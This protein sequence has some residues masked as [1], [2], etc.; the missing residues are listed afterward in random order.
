[1]AG[2]DNC[3][4]C[5]GRK[6]IAESAVRGL[7]LLCDLSAGP[8]CPQPEW[9]IEIIC[10]ANGQTLYAVLLFCEGAPKAGM[11]PS[12]FDLSG[13]A[14]TP[15]LPLRSCAAQ[16]DWEQ[17]VLCDRGNSNHQFFSRLGLMTDGNLNPDLTG[18]FEL[19]GVTAYTPVGP[20][21][22]C[23]AGD[24]EQNVFCD[25]SVSPPK[26]FISR[27]RFDENGD[28]A[29]DDT[30][31]FELD[32][33][34]VY[35]P[36]G[37][38]ALCDPKAPNTLL[39]CDTYVAL[40]ALTSHKFLRHYCVDCTSGT[41]R[42]T[43]LDG[44]TAY[45][46]LGTVGLCCQQMPVG[47][48]CYTV[49]AINANWA[50]S[51]LAGNTL[52]R[53]D[54]AK[55]TKSPQVPNLTGNN[56]QLIAGVGN[57]PQ[58]FVLDLGQELYNVVLNFTLF[59]T[60]Q[61]ETLTG[62]SPAFT[63]ATGDVTA[64]ASNTALTPTLADGN[65][66]VTFAGPVQKITFVWESTGN[67]FS[68][69]ATVAGD[70]LR[71][72]TVLRDC[73][74][75][76][77]YLDKETGAVAASPAFHDCV[78]LKLSGNT[79]I[80]AC[81]TVTI[82]GAAAPG[83]CGVNQQVIDA[84]DIQDSEEK[85]PTTGGSAVNVNDNDLEMAGQAEPGETDHKIGV[86]FTANI[87]QGATICSAYVQF[88]AEG[89]TSVDPF[90][91]RVEGEN[92]DNSAAF[93]TT[94]GMITART[95]TTANVNWTPAAW[96]NNAAGAAQRTPELKTIVQEIVNRAG[97]VAGNALAIYVTPTTNTGYRRAS[98]ILDGNEAPKLHVEYVLNGVAA[99]TTTCVHFFKEVDLST[100]EATG[101][102]Y[103]INTTTGV[104]EAYTPVGVVNEGAC[105]CPGFSGDEG[106]N[107]QVLCMEDSTG[108]Q[109]A[110]VVA[111]DGNSGAYKVVGNYDLAFAGNYTP[112]GLSA[113]CAGTPDPVDV[114]P[115]RLCDNN[116]SFIR[117][118]IYGETG[119]VTGT[120]DTALDNVTAYTPVGVVHDC[121]A[122]A[123]TQATI[124]ED[125]A[126]VGRAVVSYGPNLLS[127]GDLESS[128]GLGAT[129]APAVG[130]TT[131][132][133]PSGNIFAAG[134]QT[135]GFFATN[136]GQVTGNN[137]AAT[138]IPALG[139][140]SMA[141][142][143]G[144]NLALAILQWTNIY[145]ENGASYNLEADAAII[146]GPFGVGIRVD[147]VQIVAM[148]APAANGVWQKTSSVFT[149]T[150]ATGYHTVGI[151]SNSGVAAGNDHCFDNFSLRRAY[152]ATA[153]NRTNAPY[154][155]TVRAI[156]DQVVETANC[157][158][159][160]RDTILGNISQT[161]A[162]GTANVVLDSHLVS[163]GGVAAVAQNV[164]ALLPAG[165]KW[166]SIGAV[167]TTGTA[168][169]A[170]SDGTVTNNIPTGVAM[171]WEAPATGSLVPPTTITSNANSSVII[172]FTVKS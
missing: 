152:P 75:N 158:D 90:T 33:V 104:W 78:S 72:L 67:G 102:N 65:A 154:Q 29:A 85:N 10:D 3:A 134:A 127:N 97:W 13:T 161:L 66:A 87:P 62:F 77:T 48:R 54:G 172:I 151:H 96:V 24:F 111:I 76:V 129:S 86:R 103:R 130:W 125:C 21:G 115:I 8:D 39:L 95:K 53:S 171:R 124:L 20:V 40:G 71:T 68:T 17:N 30:G 32:G 157:N 93:T 153:E 52:T 34:T 5:N 113:P 73:D 12:Y 37:P 110:R 91:A 35:T 109:Y 2:C 105:I 119:S 167:V 80:K 82:T 123:L 142:N 59:G 136:A 70:E 43:E 84:I 14:V 116:G 46:V 4:P 79:L 150:G 98:S 64:G 121:A 11:A 156:I 170:D 165:K 22:P 99:T 133:A 122:G 7:A 117:H 74:G 69:L 106:T 166:V 118:I 28:V 107:F 144:P 26:P 146:F 137:A 139:N 47:E 81:D 41:V 140:R 114:D 50:G 160:R 88:T 128:T 101:N 147:G 1:M 164:A 108:A 143:V 89:N 126:D 61:S 56:V 15:A 168:N 155:E 45:M 25:T 9:S 145:L 120:F 149:W 19:D 49:P 36:V 60:A 141:V 100:G 163:I 92:V 31:T 138:P 132:Y 27:V 135:Y 63:S 23:T 42:D 38:V 169:V 16:S 148:T 112:V 55:I 51:V 44:T 57:S 94:A 83:V 159:D 162:T 58:T 6:L 131:Q 18:N